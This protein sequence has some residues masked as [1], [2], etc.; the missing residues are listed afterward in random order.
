MK[1]LSDYTT[2][3]NFDEWIKNK[4][5]ILL[6]ANA[7]SG[8][9]YLLLDQ[10]VS[11]IKDLKVLYCYNRTRMNEQF[12]AD[13]EAKNDNLTVVSYQ[14]LEKE[15]LFS[16]ESQYLTEYDVILCDE[17]QY[18]T[19]DSTFNK[20]TY[21]SFEKI[22]R[23]NAKK[24]Y[25]TAT[26]EPFKA[27]QHL[28]S[29]D[30]KTIDMRDLTPKNIDDI[31]ITSGSKMFKSAEEKLLKSNTIIHFEN[32]NSKNQHL[33]EI[34]K[35]KGYETT[36]INRNTKNDVTKAIESTNKEQNIFVDFIA[37]TKCN[38]TGVNFNIEGN[39][40]ATFPSIFDWTSLIQSA[41][42][43]RRF[44]NNHVSMLINTPHKTLLKSC[45]EN[46]EE[47]LKE[48]YTI[49]YDLQKKDKTFSDFFTSVLQYDFEIAMRELENKQI[50]EILQ[51]D[52]ILSFYEAKLKEIFPNADIKIIDKYDLM[53][54]EEGLNSLLG[55]ND[56]LI[57]DEEMQ[58]TIKT[59]LG[60][61]PDTIK[62]KMKD[63]FE[64]QTKR[65][66]I[67]GDKK[68]LWIIKRLTA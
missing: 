28:L 41:A 12:A 35:I 33:A 23:N 64:L 68:T 51:A 46:N 60:I 57:A 45:K 10:F 49:R 1:Y 63:K 17:C 4:K 24:I 27:I 66:T 37:T 38:E 48:L 54:I 65:K 53:P 43:L 13:Y 55:D 59:T 58:K 25:F 39:A 21:I 11:H 34:Y 47:K 26:P 32:N 42:R 52:S 61:G 36:S 18:F 6:I 62:N 15:E 14:K 20:N 7:G 19:V 16:R 56:E 50:E 3:T 9:T 30:V 40:M 2:T 31:Y 44:N 29:N 5:D 8:K 67:K 22:Q